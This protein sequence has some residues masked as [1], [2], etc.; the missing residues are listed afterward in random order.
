VV[1]YL[2]GSHAG[3]WARFY[4]WPVEGFRQRAQDA[5]D[6]FGE[7]FDVKTRLGSSRHRGKEILMTLFSWTRQEK[8]G[9]PDVF[10][11]VRTGRFGGRLYAV[12]VGVQKGDSGLRPESHADALLK[13]VT[14]AQPGVGILSWSSF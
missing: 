12:V 9:D 5:L 4:S 10:I 6:R 8:A 1:E 2:S 11:K 3:A 14:L 13:R 7:A